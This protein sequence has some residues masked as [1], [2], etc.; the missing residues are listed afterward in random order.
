MTGRSSPG[1]AY[2]DGH[3]LARLLGAGAARLLA[4][5]AHL[6]RINV[7]PVPDGDTGTNLALTFAAVAEQLA[8]QP[9]RHAGEVLVLAA[10]AALDG[11]RG[12]SGAIF[13]QYLQG[14]AAAL[15]DQPRL[16]PADLLRGLGT[17]HAWA[18][19][20]LEDPRDGTV[21]TAMAALAGEAA[22]DGAGGPAGDDFVAFFAERLAACRVAVASTRE[23]LAPLRRAGVEDAGA[24]A[25]LI[26]LEGMGDA[27]KPGLAPP[28]P[29]PAEDPPLR[30]HL[31]AG[32]AAPGG[33]RYC[34]EC[35]VA[36]AGIDAAGLRRELAA[37]ADSVVV[38]GGGDRVRVHA[39]VDVPGQ[40]FAI[41]RRHGSVSGEKADDMARQER[42]LLAG[43]RRVAVVTDSGADLPAGD[44]DELGVHLV[45]MR[46]HL[47]ARSF[48]DKVELGPAALLR[49]LAA[50]PGQATTSQPAPGDF[51]RA[52][53]LLS[54][55]F[56][57]VVSISIS[58]R[59]SGTLQAAGAAAR[60][61]TAGRITVIDSRSASV[62][63]GLVVRAAAERARAGASPAEVTAAAEDAAGNTRTYG[64]IRDLRHAVRG[65]RIPPPW[66][67]LAAR[68]PVSFVMATRGDGSVGVRRVLPRG[69]GL[70]DP[71]LGPA[72][73]DARRSGRHRLAIG[74]A[75]DPEAADRLRA[76]CE[77]RFP[78]LESVTVAE[79]G[80]AF[81]VHGGPGTLVLA[82]QALPG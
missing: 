27:L 32:A 60:Q 13:A 38:V 30:V 76:R 79:L 49:E 62:G 48:L 58:G 11:A 5:R 75:G 72:L 77:A 81:G 37:V 78:G 39:H 4:G 82:V 22:V 8:A 45:P 53:A 56:E 57:H 33:G 69:M 42:A 54:S 55:H 25:L 36:G 80:P 31:E 10:D 74:H 6:D 24:L 35:L 43:G 61:G 65:G 19:S 34:T 66:R 12:N 3:R 44:F 68:A 21:L 1:I 41:A 16:V 47:G 67:W 70:V 29:A 28:A 51:R 73:R 20:A 50:N 18:R 7:F 2:L 17:A 52:Y 59:L 46:V 64:A 63:Q 40:V 9:T 71:V 23:T 14:L 26:L 15:R